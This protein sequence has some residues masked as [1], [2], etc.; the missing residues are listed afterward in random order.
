MHT[1]STSI[2]VVAAPNT[3]VRNKRSGLTRPQAPARGVCARARTDFRTRPHWCAFLM[4]RLPSFHGSRRRSKHGAAEASVGKHEDGAAEHV[5]VFRNVAAVV[6]DLPGARRRHSGSRHS[7]N[8]S[9]DTLMVGC[10][11]RFAPHRLWRCWRCWLS[12]AARMRCCCSISLLRCFVL[13]AFGL[14]FGDLR[15]RVGFHAR[16]H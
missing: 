14:L 12:S 8:S 11:S 5:P 10:M 3:S 15:G 16:R 9:S 6:G 4:H 1:P 7:R 2:P 13:L